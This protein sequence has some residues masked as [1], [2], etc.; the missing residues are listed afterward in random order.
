MSSSE[1]EGERDMAGQGPAALVP[2]APAPPAAAPALAGAQPVLP[3]GGE[4]AGE[5]GGAERAMVVAR[6]ELQARMLAAAREEGRAG[7]REEARQVAEERMD[8]LRA[9]HDL[10]F[11]K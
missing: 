2:A 6:Q 10:V 3:L 5:E 9:H 8:E 11:L 1:D 4:R 7:A